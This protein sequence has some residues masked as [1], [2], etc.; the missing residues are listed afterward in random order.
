MLPEIQNMLARLPEVTTGK[1]C[2][3][4]N[5][6]LPEHFY[7]QCKEVAT[8]YVQEQ[9]KKEF[10]E[11]KNRAIST[12]KAALADSEEANEVPEED[13]GMIVIDGKS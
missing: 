9:A 1:E 10:L 11:V 3:F 6:W 8:K 4:K 7:E 2:D 12:H 5:G 13:I